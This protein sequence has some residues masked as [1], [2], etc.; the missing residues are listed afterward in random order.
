MADDTRQASAQQNEDLS[1]EA[2]NVQPE[3]KPFTGTQW[4][5]GKQLPYRPPENA[6]MM[7]GGTEH[8]AGGKTP[9]VS[10]SNAF[11]G[12]IK[13]SDFTELP[14][15]PCVRDALMTGI[16]SGFAFGGIRAIFGAAVWTSCTWAVGSFCLGAPA[17]YQFCLYKRQAEKE[18]M[19]RAVEILNK[20]DTE[21]KAREA[22]KEKAREER[23]AQKETELDAQF[24]ALNEAKPNTV[25]HNGGK[26]WWKIW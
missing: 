14:K 9:D 20:K 7:A 10:L 8:T 17:M 2:L 22:R 19:M 3:N 24:A 4:Q 18:G 21:K 15:R 16:G 13:W 5:G 23:R 11:D 26:P 6:N 1:K 12:G 25:S